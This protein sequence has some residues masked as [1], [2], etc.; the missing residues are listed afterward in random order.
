MYVQQSN[1]TALVSV[2]ARWY[3]SQINI[4]KI[5]DDSMAG[6]LLTDEEKSAIS[7]SMSKGISFFNPAFSGPND[8][9]LRWIVDNQLSPTPLG[10]AAFAEWHLQNAIRLGAKQYIILAAGYDSFA[11]RQPEWASAVQ[12]IEIDHPDTANDKKRRLETAKIEIP[13]N[14]HYISADFNNPDWVCSLEN[15]PAFKRTALSFCSLLGISYY[16]PKESFERMIEILSGILPP[17]S[18]IVFDYPDENT[19]TD[20]AGERAKKQNMLAAGAN[21]VMLASYSYS[22]M[23]RLLEKHNFLMYEHLTPE[24][25]T[26][27]WF[28]KYNQQN[29][30]HIMTAFD[31]VNYCIAVKQ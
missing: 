29:P 14:T 17:K 7:E 26:S 5:F 9:A 30:N 15:H 3:H 31:N 28:V 2:F 13:N 6:T 22:D 20:K 16:L 21:E 4:V 18:S 10:R 25:I 12:I 23:E 8:E 1:M 19:Y 27:Q 24:E 11:Y